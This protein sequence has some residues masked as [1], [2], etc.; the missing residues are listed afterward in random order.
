MFVFIM[1]DIESIFCPDREELSL[2]EEEVF[3][4][5]IVDAELDTISIKFLGDECAH[6]NA[7]GYTYLCLSKDNL[8][9]IVELMEAAEEMYEDFN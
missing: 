7:D 1:K 3:E 2:N 4:T 8:K 6:I 5:K 9:R